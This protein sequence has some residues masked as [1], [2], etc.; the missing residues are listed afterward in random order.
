MFYKEQ[1]K[2]IQVLEIFKKWWNNYD[3]RASLKRGSHR[4]KQLLNN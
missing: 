1:D 3:L 4:S 2:I